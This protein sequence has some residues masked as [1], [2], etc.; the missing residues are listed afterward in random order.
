MPT[1]HRPR[2]GSASGPTL[3]PAGVPGAPPVP[4]GRV[5]PAGVEFVAV[6]WDH[7]LLTAVSKGGAAEVAVPASRE[8]LLIVV[9]RIFVRTNSSTATDM[10]A[11]LG[12]AKDE[13]EVE[14]T[15]SGNRDVADE[16]QPILVPAGTPFTLRWTGCTPAND[17][18]CIAR[19]QYRL[20]FLAA[21]PGR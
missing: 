17:T 6:G 1:G 7:V 21:A 3:V 4:A 9:D 5:G 10:T 19:V 12:D 11:Y 16:N 2:R 8:G 14:F 20:G 15:A 18:V 13:N